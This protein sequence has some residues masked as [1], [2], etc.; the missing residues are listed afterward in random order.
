MQQPLTAE[1]TTFT[2][3]T[4]GRYLANTLHEALASAGAASARS[5]PS[6]CS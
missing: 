1:Y 4:M 5:S 3:D 2:L 6:G